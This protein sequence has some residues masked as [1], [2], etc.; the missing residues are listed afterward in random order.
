MALPGGELGYLAKAL[1]QQHGVGLSIGF[2]TLDSVHSVC[3]EF[4]SPHFGDTIFK[5]TD[6]DLQT[7]EITDGQDQDPG[8]W[9]DVID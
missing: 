4:G 5:A 9:I 7:V 8:T 1:S 6:I 2:R 3:R